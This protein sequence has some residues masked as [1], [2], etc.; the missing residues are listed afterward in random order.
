M[1]ARLGKSVHVEER[2]AALLAQMQI[3]GTLPPPPAPAPIRCQVCGDRGI[4]GISKDRDGAIVGPGHPLFGKSIPCPAADCEEGSKARRNRFERLLS[5]AG[6]PDTYKSMTFASFGELDSQQRRG[7]ELAAGAA[8]AFANSSGRNH[9]YSLQEAAAAVT[10]DQSL[11]NRQSPE[12]KNWLVLQGGLGMGKT[13]LAAA[14]VNEMSAGLVPVLFFRLQEMF[15]E[16][17]SRYGKDAS[18]TADEL[19]LEIQRAPV[20]ILDEFN[21]SNVSND[22]ARIIE[23]VIRYR[24]G[25][26]LATVITCNV[27]QR[28][29][30]AMWGDRTADVIFERAHW[31]SLG[32]Q[33]L[34]RTNSAVESF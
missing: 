33:K 2:I 16:I 31:I 4:V 15:Q 12:A 20:L 23:E 7:K 3:D 34:R 14:I 24:H 6:L 25:R 13:G 11:I 5:K 32:G 9:M 30:S 21:V 8:Y 29:M 28:G 17:Q 10:G 26:S 19:I 22:K 18:P 27:D 1:S